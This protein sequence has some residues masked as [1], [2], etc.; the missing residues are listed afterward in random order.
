MINE[1]YQPE[2][3]RES[4][5]ARIDRLIS[6][7]SNA[8]DFS[9]KCLRRIFHFWNFM[10]NTAVYHDPGRDVFRFEESRVGRI[11]RETIVRPVREL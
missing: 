4:Q 2:A 10:R 9:E 3:E 7:H 5:Y 8:R 1:R 6:P 11:E